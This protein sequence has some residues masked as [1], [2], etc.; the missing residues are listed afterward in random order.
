MAFINNVDELQ[1]LLNACSSTSEWEMF[2]LAVKIGYIYIYTRFQKGFHIE[3]Y[4]DRYILL[5]SCTCARVHFSP[6]IVQLVKKLASTIIFFF[7]GFFFSN[8]KRTC[9]FEFFG[10]FFLEKCMRSAIQICNGELYG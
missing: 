9:R 3:R 1:A 6:V 7:D 10:F 8:L 4:I 2:Y 5:F